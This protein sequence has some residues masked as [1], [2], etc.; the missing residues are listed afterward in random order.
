MAK[1]KASSG[2]SDSRREA[3]RGLTRGKALGDLYR[4]HAA[5]EQVI[6]ESAEDPGE[7]DLH[8]RLG[9]VLTDFLRTYP[10]VAAALDVD[11]MKGDLTAT[12]SVWVI[13]K[14][15]ERHLSPIMA[16]ARKTAGGKRT[17]GLAKAEQ[18]LASATDPAQEWGHGEALVYLAS[19]GMQE[20]R[21]KLAAG[22]RDRWRKK[23]EWFD[24]KGRHLLVV[25][26]PATGED[27]PFDEI[28]PRFW[29][30]TG[31]STV[32]ATMVRVAE[33]LGFT[34]FDPWWPKLDAYVALNEAPSLDSQS[35]YPAH[36]LFSLCRSDKAMKAMPNAVQAL[37]GTVLRGK[38]DASRPWVV[39]R[40]DPEEPD[41]DEYERMESTGIAASIAFAGR[42]VPRWPA[43]ETL[44]RDAEGF[45]IGK[46][47]ESG[48]W[49]GVNEEL[50]AV[51]SIRETAMAIHALRLGEPSGWALAVQRG[52]DWLWTQQDEFGRW[53]QPGADPVYLTVLV[54]DAVALGN[55]AS[56]KHVTFTTSPNR[57]KGALAA[58]E[59]QA[60][61][62]EVV[63][64]VKG[65]QWITVTEAAKLLAKDPRI[66][67][68]KTKGLVSINA[69]R[70]KFRTNGKKGRDRRIDLDSF[71]T[72]RITQRDRDLDAEH[73]A[74]DEDD[75]ED[76]DG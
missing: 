20:V 33:W 72:W 47:Q 60:D 10:L 52:V 15:L 65:E 50:E 32:D 39:L 27:K 69:N 26:D 74:A 75:A 62:G 43:G 44:V 36:Q 40:E 38:V 67:A 46:Q 3:L 57:R 22:V 42:R 37:L 14:I 19:R 76:E 9:R 49:L 61:L 29:L 16:A 51:E 24:Q 68:A 53:S 8:R 25:V 71:N 54:L 4:L 35:Q 6:A 5:C 59:F 11:T 1:R 73:D 34:E 31:S 30:G 23:A 70:R 13:Q 48:A 2:G 45:L 12:D 58:R 64:E 17:K 7:V 66:S 55:G 63:G 28:P 41:A 56:S 21:D 18:W